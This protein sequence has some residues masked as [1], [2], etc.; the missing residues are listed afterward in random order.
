MSVSPAGGAPVDARPK[1]FYANASVGEDGDA[2]A[3]LLDGRGVKT[4]AG[5]VLRPP[6][7]ALAD[8]IASEWAEQGE[9]IDV[10]A[11][12]LTRL[13]NVAQ[14]RGAVT[15]T[16]LAD[17]VARY[18]E[19]DLVCHLADDEPALRDE[20]D[21]AWGPLRDWAGDTLGARLHVA[22]GVIA[23]RQPPESVEAVRAAAGG[24][25]AW[26]LTGLAH[27]TGLLGSAVL[28][29]ALQ[30]GRI[31]ADAAFAASRID[32]T[33]QERR[34]GVDEEAAMRAEGLRADVRAVAAFFTALDG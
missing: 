31:D 26:R 21:A 28:A 34:W 7:R 13:A 15:H 2:F 1:R 32:E 17:E 12:A 27:A 5:A 3:I 18:A 8:A 23:V 30:R 14:D 9:R 19:T 24:L 16:E 20:Q 29:L 10:H 11:M 25:D 6:T 4:P 33:F 22:D